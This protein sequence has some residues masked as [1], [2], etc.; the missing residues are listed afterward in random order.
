[1]PPVGVTDMLPLLKPQL[2]W[3]GVAAAVIPDEV[4]NVVDAVAVHPPKVTVT[5]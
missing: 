1:M 3:V 4:F 2:G 5:V